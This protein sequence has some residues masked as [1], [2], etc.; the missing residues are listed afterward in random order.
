MY[1][2]Q[3]GIAQKLLHNLKYKR[4]K[5]IGVMLG[6]W[7]AQEL[8]D[9]KVDC[10]IPVPIH[11]QKQRVRGY[12][13]SDF[14]AAGISE[15]LGLEIQSNAISR[16]VLGP[17]QTMKSKV[18]RWSDLENVYSEVITNLEG[19]KVLIVDDVVT[20]GA[21]VGMLSDRLIEAGV[22][23]IHIATLARDK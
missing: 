9:T 5:E 14:I 1:F 19:T 13:Q 7:F 4:K 3:D 22:K 6:N 17:S 15:V 20:T 10:I 16:I 2:H 21:T 12:N 11:K 23:E 18:K 8:H